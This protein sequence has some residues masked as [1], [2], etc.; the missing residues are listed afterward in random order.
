MSFTAQD[1]ADP[2]GPAYIEGHVSKIAETK[3]YFIPECDEYAMAVPI[4]GKPLEIDFVP[5]TKGSYTLRQD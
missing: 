3:H 4:S 2:S 5:W 1:T